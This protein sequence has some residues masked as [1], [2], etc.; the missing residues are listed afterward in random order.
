[1]VDGFNSY[2]YVQDN[3]IRYID[4]F[5]LKIYTGED[6]ETICCTKPQQTWQYWLYQSQDE[7]QAHFLLMLAI[8]MGSLDKYAPATIAILIRLMKADWTSFLVSIGL[9]IYTKDVLRRVCDVTVC[10]KADIIPVKCELYAY[11]VFGGLYNCYRVHCACP[12]GS[13]S[14]GTADD[15]ISRPKMP[16]DPPEWDYEKLKERMRKEKEERDAAMPKSWWWPW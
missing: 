14:W 10:L 13:T 7:C 12:L 4:P 1:M 8:N 5:G 15:P 3:P 9:P 6:P 16:V 11:P 2:A